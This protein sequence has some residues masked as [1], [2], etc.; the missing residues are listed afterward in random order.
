MQLGLQHLTPSFNHGFSSLC[1]SET[2]LSTSWMSTVF[3]RLK[4][5]HT[6]V[7]SLLNSEE[8]LPLISIFWWDLTCLQRKQNA[9]HIEKLKETEHK[10]LKPIRSPMAYQTAKSRHT[11]CRILFSL[12]N[13]LRLHM[14]TMTSKEHIV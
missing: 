9:P 1:N 8:E 14:H 7:Y 6:L 4:S 11:N 13:I 2:F 3:K 12:P 5:A 10:F